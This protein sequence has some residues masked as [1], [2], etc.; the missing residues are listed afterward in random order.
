MTA[1]QK[2]EALAGQRY[3][4]DKLLALVDEVTTHFR[5]PK[6]KTISGVAFFRMSSTSDCRVSAL[7]KEFGWK[8]CSRRAT[9]IAG[10]R[11]NSLICGSAN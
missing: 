9:H 1:F 7:P 11:T 3:D 10:V 4:R 2:A 6:M 8:A 5:M